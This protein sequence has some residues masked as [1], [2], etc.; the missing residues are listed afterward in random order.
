M[1]DEASKENIVFDQEQLDAVAAEMANML[2]TPMI[3]SILLLG[4][5]LDR[6][7]VI[8][9]EEL[10]NAFE[11]GIARFPD[12]EEAEREG[13]RASLHPAPRIGTQ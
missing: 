10:A 3:H 4:E 12:V 6:D 13:G 7:G 8:G 11:K 5:A 2:V 9:F 1:S